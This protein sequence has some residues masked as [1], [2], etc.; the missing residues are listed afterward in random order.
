[1]LLR[2]GM[3]AVVLFALW[4]FCVLD[5][6]MTEESLVRNLPKTA[7]VLIVLFLPDVGS[8]VWLIAGRPPKAAFRPGAT[9]PRPAFRP[10]G[11][12]PDDDTAFLRSLR[13]GG[14]SAADRQRE[15]R[16]REWEEELRRREEKLRGDGGDNP[17]RGDHPSQG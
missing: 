13:E 15:R 14:P 16:L 4:V 9:E 10:S 2:Y 12:A 11:A 1:M 5:V 3:P 8:I 17:S 6:I 7:W